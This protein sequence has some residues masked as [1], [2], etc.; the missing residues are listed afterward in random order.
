MKFSEIS[1]R[2]CIPLKRDSVLMGQEKG[3][4]FER[5][6]GLFLKNQNFLVK[7]RFRDAGTEIDL[8]CENRLSKEIVVVECKAH[9]SSL[10]S[11]VVNKLLA[12]MQVYDANGG[13]IFSTSDLGK[14]A[15]TR[16]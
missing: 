10:K 13:W 1:Y 16:M 6:V 3:R 12:D 5:F 7:D 4:L 2:I 11:E 14:E 9:E 8:L 15:R